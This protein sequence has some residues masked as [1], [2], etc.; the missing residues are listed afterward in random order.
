M[1]FESQA[2]AEIA[3]TDRIA[4][5][6]TAGLFLYGKKLSQLTEVPGGFKNL[7][8]AVFRLTNVD[9][10]VFIDL[11]LVPRELLLV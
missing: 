10:I 4:K 7:V 2:K 8:T 6:E 3:L 1:S 9:H 11:G 5:L